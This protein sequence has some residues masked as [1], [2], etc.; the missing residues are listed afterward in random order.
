MWAMIEEKLVECHQ[1]RAP[2]FHRPRG[3][4]VNKCE[5]APQN[6][7]SGS[8]E[9]GA[10]SAA[11][12]RKRILQQLL[13]LHGRGDREVQQRHLRQALS[14]DSGEDWAALGCGPLSVP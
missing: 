10:T 7:Y 8:A 6:P 9:T 12:K 11:T 4:I 14:K 1:L 13:L 3:K 2:G 5:E